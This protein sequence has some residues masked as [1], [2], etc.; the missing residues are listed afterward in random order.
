[1]GKLEQ[2]FNRAAKMP[3]GDCAFPEPGR[4][5]GKIEHPHTMTV[6]D[7]TSR[8]NEEESMRFRRSILQMKDDK[9]ITSKDARK[10]LSSVN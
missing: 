8:V 10:I 2:I 9:V 4:D 6:T 5:L 1:M 3:A 7:T